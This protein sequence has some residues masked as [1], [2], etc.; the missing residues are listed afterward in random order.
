MENENVQATSADRPSVTPEQIIEAML[1]ADTQSVAVDKV[2]PKEEPQAEAQPPEDAAPAEPNAQEEGAEAPSEPVAE[3][4][5]EQLESIEL[6]VTV[7]E[8]DGRDVT[9][10]QSIKELKLGYMRQKDYQRKTQEVARQRNEVEA[11]VRQ[12]V[13][14]ERAQYA[15]TLAALQAAVVEA[16]EPE[17][18]NVNWNQL[19]NENPAEYVRLRNRADQVANALQTAKAKQN[20]VLARQRAE[21][22]QALRKAAAESRQVLEKDIP[23]WNDTLYQDLLQ[24][25][26]KVGFKPDE[27]GQWV[28]PRA[29]KL[30]HKAHLY[31]QLQATKPPAEKKVVAVPKVIKPGSTT[32][33]NP[34]QVKQKEALERVQKSGR[35]QDAAELIKA[36]L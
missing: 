8:E 24:Q 14:A 25:G 33:T 4:P 15:Q 20:E 10:K 11:K 30:L 17:L 23:G 5:L 1:N 35:W 28:D 12:G 19:A 22:D 34:A 3:I 6:E 18:R 16:V 2:A 27:V 31:D 36:R 26:L 29:I 9:E 32:K 7:K 13:E 21:S